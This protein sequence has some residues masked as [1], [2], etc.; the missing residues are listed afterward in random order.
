MAIVDTAI[1]GWPIIA[2]DNCAIFIVMKISVDHISNVQLSGC[3]EN[4]DT[5]GNSL[6]EVCQR[7]GW[8]QTPCGMLSRKV[9]L[10]KAPG[11]CVDWLID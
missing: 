7:I 9:A 5:M 11:D 6:K 2:G 1:C 4:G 10:Q 8:S 3:D